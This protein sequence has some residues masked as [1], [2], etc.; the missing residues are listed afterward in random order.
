MR[1]AGKEGLRAVLV[2][3]HNYA[4]KSRILYVA[5]DKGMIETEAG[6]V[7]YQDFSTRS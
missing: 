1:I 7:S 6:K 2:R 3:L 5:R 4:E